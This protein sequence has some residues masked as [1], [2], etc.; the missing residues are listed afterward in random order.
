MVGPAT[1]MPTLPAGKG[2]S[3]VT[4]GTSVPFTESERVAGPLAEPVQVTSIRF[5]SWIGTGC[6]P[7]E[8]SRTIGLVL[9]VSSSWIDQPPEELTMK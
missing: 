4:D 2:V 5:T 7:W 1:A 3:S 6:R 9:P 8:S